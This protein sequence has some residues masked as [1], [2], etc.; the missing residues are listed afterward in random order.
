MNNCGTCGKPCQGSHCDIH[1]RDLEDRP[2]S[3]PVCYFC[4]KTLRGSNKHSGVC[5]V[6]YKEASA[7]VHRRRTCLSCTRM[8]RK[9]GNLY[10]SYHDECKR[11]KRVAAQDERRTKAFLKDIDSLEKAMVQQED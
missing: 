7:K 8:P 5:S 9:V 4:E 6:C 3:A 10:C 2:M 1:L 11:Q